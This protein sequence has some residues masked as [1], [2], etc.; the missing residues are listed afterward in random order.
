MNYILFI[1]VFLIVLFLYLHINHQLKVSNDLGIIELDKPT[2]DELEM[3]C[4]IK[5]PIIFKYVNDDI[6]QLCNLNSITQFYSKYELNLIDKEKDAKYIININQLQDLLINDKNGV[7]TSHNNTLF[8]KEMNLDTIL[9]ENDVFLKPSMLINTKYDIIL[10]S[11]NS[12]LKLEYND[13]YRNYLYVTQGSVNIRLIPPKYTYLLY[14]EKDYLNYNF[15]S[16]INVWNVQPE[17]INKFNKVKYVDI[18]LKEGDMIYV[19]SYWWYSLQFNR[20]SS[21]CKFQYYTYMNYLSI[22]PTILMHNIYKVKMKQTKNFLKTETD[23]YKL[24]NE[25]DNEITN[26]TEKI[27]KNK[28]E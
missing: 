10:G 25:H 15:Y 11:Q 3:E 23:V 27:E 7:I 28:L 12:S 21:I 4:D 20:I 26:E 19:P 8:I 13:S 9:N 16:L 24:N 2:K 14:H 17:Y 1:F 6:K 5:Q 22:L 18:T